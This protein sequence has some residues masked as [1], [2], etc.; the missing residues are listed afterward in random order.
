MDDLEG[1]DASGA[2]GA[3]V[4]DATLCTSELVT[5]SCVHA[6]GTGAVLLL[7][8][9][10]EAVRVTVY[11]EDRTPPAL[12]EGYD[13]ESGRG[14]WIVDALTEGRWGTELPAPRLGLD[15]SEGKGVWF[16]LGKG[17][18]GEAACSSGAVEACRCAGQSCS[19]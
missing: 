6:K 18:S 9:E 15:G 7:T 16:E 1:L 2:L 17:P 5:N 3:L 19:A 12:R 11:D 10:R 8:A 14:L 13:G 4:D